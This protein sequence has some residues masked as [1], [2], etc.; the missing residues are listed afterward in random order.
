MCITTLILNIAA[1]AYDTENKF[2]TLQRLRKRVAFFVARASERDGESPS[3]LKL[4]AEL[5]LRHRC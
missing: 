2:P 5:T 4:L 1:H 3:A